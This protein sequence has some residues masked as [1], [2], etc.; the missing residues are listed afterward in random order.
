[1]TGTKG[2]VL[3]DTLHINGAELAQAVLLRLYFLLHQL[4][5]RKLAEVF[6]GN[7]MLMQLVEMTV[8]FIGALIQML[9]RL[10]V[11]T[12]LLHGLL[13]VTRTMRRMQLLLPV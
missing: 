11:T 5:Y 2:N 3:G 1:M 6:W 7:E 12:V 13:Q 4:M 10:T 9:Q 8:Q